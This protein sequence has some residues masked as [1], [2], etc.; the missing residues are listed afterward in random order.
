MQRLNLSNMLAK[1][2][3]ASTPHASVSD[4]K[5]HTPTLAE[6]IV[7]FNTVESFDRDQLGLAVAA[8][9]DNDVSVVEGSFRKVQS[10]GHPAMHGF[11][12]LNQEVR[13]YDETASAKGMQ[14]VASNMLMDTADDSLWSITAGPDGQKML[15]R[16]NDKDMAK[17][18]TTA[19][20]HMH[21]QPVLAGV[22]YEVNEGEFAAFIDAT[23]N[24]VRYG[25]VLA[26]EGEGMVE[27]LPTDTGAA[28]DTDNQ[29]GGEN[30][31][32]DRMD[33]EVQPVK[34]DVAFV[35]EVARVAENVAVKFEGAA[36]LPTDSRSKEA[37]RAYYKQLYSYDPSY[38]SDIEKQIAEHSEM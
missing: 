23:T 35:V 11:V 13:A 7:S 10:F 22:S 21:N 3:T 33:M 12:K 1:L 14:A 15:S 30:K 38:Y 25:Y 6:V 9:F 28:N 18:M 19:K 29:R 27:I 4:F 34:V 24:S 20:V 5:M 17:L 8:A 32:A 37:M 2:T 31:V 16:Q 36:E 26:N